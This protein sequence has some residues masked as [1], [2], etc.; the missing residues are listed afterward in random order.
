MS[1]YVLGRDAERD[2][3]DL[4]DYLAERSVDSAD[5]LTG[6]LFQAFESIA[7][8]PGIGH[9]R[10]DLTASSVLFWP[11]GKYLVIY[12]VVGNVVEIAAVVHGKRDVPAYLRQRSD[13]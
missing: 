10:E 3:E 4:W 13:S 12:R 6:Q 7:Q 8:N 11:V 1:A 5:Y 2:L 9:K